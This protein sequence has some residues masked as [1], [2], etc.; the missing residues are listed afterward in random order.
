MMV[1]FLRLSPPYRLAEHAI[2]NVTHVVAVGFKP[3]QVG[4]KD[5]HQVLIQLHIGQCGLELYYDGWREFYRGM[6][7]GKNVNFMYSA[8]W[9]KREQKCA[10][11]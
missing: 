3:A 6:V 10:P 1:L 9:T 5:L 11:F 8:V 2:Y 7:L 4:C